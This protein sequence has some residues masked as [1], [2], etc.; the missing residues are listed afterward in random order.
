MRT[1]PW[2]VTRIYTSR[3]TQNCGLRRYGDPRR[4][5]INCALVLDDCARR[6]GRAVLKAK[7]EGSFQGFPDRPVSEGRT[8]SRT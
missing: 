1:L 7:V 6:S 4:K 8:T 2:S 3:P 5:Y